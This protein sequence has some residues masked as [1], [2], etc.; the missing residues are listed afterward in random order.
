MT[1]SMLEKQATHSHIL[2][3]E[4]GFSQFFAT[5][6]VQDCSYDIM[7]PNIKLDAAP[8]L[9]FFCRVVD[10]M[11]TVQLQKVVKLVLLQGLCLMA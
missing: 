3:K 1:K 8:F 9:S 5:N 10:C 7:T 4:S 2:H 11:H 6:F